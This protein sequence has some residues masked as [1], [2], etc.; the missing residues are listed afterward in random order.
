LVVK[1]Q[2]FVDTKNTFRYTKMTKKNSSLEEQRKRDESNYNQGRLQAD[3]KW[4]NA[5]D[6]RIKELEKQVGIPELR[7]L[8]KTTRYRW[9]D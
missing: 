4:I 5:I 8:K 3:G 7:L 1:L 9:K 6:E 2:E